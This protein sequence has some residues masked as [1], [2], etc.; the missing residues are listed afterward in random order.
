M[1]MNRLLR[2]CLLWLCQLTLLAQ[3]NTNLLSNGSF[4]S[5]TSGQP[6]N[7][8]TASSAGNAVLSPSNEARSGSF[9]ALVATGQTANK[10]LAY[11]ETALKA[12]TYTFSIY[13]KSTTADKSQM[14]MGYVSVVDGKAGTYTYGNYEELSNSEWI[15]Y[16][17]TFTL[18]T[19]T[20]VCLLV[21][22][23]KKS[24]N[25]VAQDILVD[26]AEL[27]T[28]DGGLDVYNPENP[29]NPETP[30]ET[31]T[32]TLQVTPSSAGSLNTSSPSIYRED[33]QVW[34]AAYNYSGY[35]FL[36]WEENGEKISSVSSFY[37]TMPGRDATLKA[38]FRYNPSNPGNPETPPTKSMLYLQSEPDGAGYFNWGSPSEIVCGNDVSVYAYSNVGWRFREWQVDGVSVS[39]DVR[40]YFNMPEDDL[41]LVAVFDYNPSNP[42][43]PATN[44][45]NR[46]LGEVIV[47]DFAAGSVYST[48]YNLVGG[49][50]EAVKMIT[51]AGRISDND[52]GAANNF[53]QCTTLD[54]SRTTGMMYVPGWMFYGNSTLNEVILPSTIT[55]IEDYGF[56][57]GTGLTSITCYAV[58]P[59]SVGYDAFTGVSTDLVVYVPAASVPLYQNADGWKNLTILPLQSEV[60]SLEVNFPENIDITF[61]KNAY[62]ELLNINSGQKR[63]YL[64]TDRLTYT[65]SSLLHN[66]S[67][68]VYLKNEKEDMLGKIENV[69]VKDQDMSVTF[70]DL[71][72]PRDVELKVLNT[73]NE[74]LT[75]QVSIT[76][77]DEEGNFLARGNKLSNLLEGYKVRYHITLPRQL[78]MKYQMPED[79]LYEIQSANN[80]TVELENIPLMMISGA[81]MDLKQNTMLP[82][83][84]VSVS[85]TLNGQYSKTVVTK[86]DADGLWSLAAF[87]APTDIT[88][89]KMGF[90]SQSVSYEKPV[91]DVPVFKLR[92]ING[93]T[94]SLNLTYTNIKGETQNGYSDYANVAFTVKNKATGEEITDLNLQYPQIVLMDQL[95]EGTEF[96]ITATSKKGSFMPV[97]ASSTAVD[98]LDKASVTLPIK[99]FGGIT[100]SFAQALNNSMV[101]ILYDASGRL[102]K[103][104]DYTNSTLVINELVDGVYTLVTMGGSQFFNG[105]GSIS[106]FAEAGL[107]EGVDY[108]KNKVTVESA[109]MVYI[110]NQ[111]IPYLDETK[112]YY[113][114]NN[115]SFTVNKTQVT[116]GQYLTL[117]G[118]VDFKSLY[119]SHVSNVKLVVSLPEGV[120]F[121]E[122]SVMEGNSTTAYTST[123]STITIPIKNMNNRI[124]LCVIPTKGG[125]LS[126]SAA[127]QFTYNGKEMTQPIGTVNFTAKDLSINVPATVSL[128]SVPVSGTAVGRSKVEIFENGVLAG[129]TTSL[130]NGSWA[131]TIELNDYF[132]LSTHDIYAQVTTQQGVTMQS[133]TRRVTY[134]SHAIQVSKVVM[135]HWNPEANWWRGKNYEVIFDFLN[136]TNIAQK[137]VYYIYNKVFTFTIEF[138]E[139]DPS[140]VTDVVL[141][142]KLGSGAWAPVNAV[143][144]SNSKKWVASGEFGNMYDGNIPINVAISCKYNGVPNENLIAH[145]QESGCED[146]DPSIDPSGYV[147]EGVSSNRLQGVTA[148]AYY[149]ETVED[150]YG[151]LHENIV[152]WNAEEYAQE[153]PLFTDEMGMYRWDV[154]QG[155]WRVKFEKDG[156]Q[157]TYSE[158]LP[159]P[160]PQLDVNIPMTQMSQP[161][162][163]SALVFEE[164]VDIE[165]DKYMDPATLTTENIMVTKNDVAVNGSI[166]LLNEE[167]TYEGKEQT[168]ASKVRFVMPDGD[169]LLSTDEVRLTVRLNVKSY[170]GIPMESDYQQAFEVKKKVKSI[171]IEPVLNIG[172]GNERTISVAV[173]PADA[174]K[175]KKLSIRSMAEMIATVSSEELTL[176][177]N[178]EAELTVSGKLPGSTVLDFSVEDADV[179]TMVTVNVKE[180]EKLVTVAPKA[181]RVSGTEVY[182]GTKIQL[183]SDTKDATIYYTLDGSNPGDENNENVLVYNS[184]QPIIIAS[185]NVTI[186]AIARG[187]DLTDSEVKEFSYSLKKTTLGYQLNGWNWISHNV[188]NALSVSDF[189]SDF[190]ATPDRILSQT[191]EVINDPVAGLIGN[192]H[193]LQPAVGYKIK[194][195]A[196][197]EKNLT[198]NEYNATE[199]AVG[200]SAGWNWIGYPLN[201][202]MS[203][204]EAL[205]FFTPSEGDYIVGQDGFVEFADGSWQGTLGGF[206]P[207]NAY[208]YKS[209]VNTEIAFN[210]TIVSVAASRVGKRNV[211]MNSP[212]AYDSHAWQDNMPV[213][214]QLRVNGENVGADDYLVAAFSDTEC[215]GIGQWK[216]GRLMMSVYGQAGDDIRFIALDLNDKK[217]YDIHE[218][219]SLSADNVGTWHMPYLLTLGGETTDIQKLYNDLTVTPTVAHD[220]LT[221]S[222]GGRNIDRLTLTNTGGVQ[223]VSVSNLGK[224]ATVATGMLPDGVYILTVY[225][226]GKTFYKKIIKA[227]K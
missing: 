142:V 46:Q 96:L 160:P 171:A 20:T 155:L 65:F 156:Y 49:D 102:V 119:A 192:L 69:E 215:R 112:F 154:P 198:G 95:P 68:I 75:D 88:A 188:E 23:P 202:I 86:T 159:V 67:Y 166:Q 217:F 224:G 12:G 174:S 193:E 151:D 22:N 144:D 129:Q 61:Y 225:A 70:T 18:N 135:Y 56:Y 187:N 182:R 115:T 64:V 29:P 226:E 214:A 114:G 41:T 63:R 85:Q 190:G 139:N 100:A 104:Y 10:R 141:Y 128:P 178:G 58:T 126:A 14:R 209:A 93:T 213:T 221:V 32:L 161:Y 227:N 106:Q 162:V 108:V 134:D 105:V 7:W 8:V 94:I 77:S 168:Y 118:H 177:E 48:I 163:K 183:S 165:F 84:V 74:D 189:V 82:N 149:K 9:S 33:T 203:I 184:D 124:R 91:E 27:T 55:R 222:A 31:Y 138:T 57:Y 125:E 30:K 92:D 54:M 176:D 52:W 1:T 35:E 80:L 51:I 133:E 98:N 97:E 146:A 196:Q 87:D 59:P 36:Y 110:S 148:T 210:T 15:Q 79:A 131:T 44:Y 200:L 167:A 180:A 53:P 13:A 219:L 25:N 71:V 127:V 205:A 101:G 83:A 211:L 122:N 11:Q 28:S 130:A 218:T 111:I 223:V 147:Y 195:A 78:G 145:G 186:K 39:Q 199:N 150:M 197:T 132:D 24:S 76:W 169:K 109:K 191:Q 34:L 181:S 81:V 19:S 117:T 66:T 43:N 164:G 2:I 6:D 140:K 207:G 40:Y 170:A 123:E 90:V 16:S 216:D 26:D 201:Q 208:L 5:W 137:Y 173:L 153:N 62:I 136:P 220:H 113:T 37:Y 50:T 73:K 99:Q 42:G 38:V 143:Y 72:V 21:M 194:V 204:D 121:V 172:Y 152:L 107:R 116:V 103:K 212:W 157:T 4:E 45:W 120:A 47:D 89:S 158:W 175:G 185:D 206:V 60:A 3:A 17:Y 179:N